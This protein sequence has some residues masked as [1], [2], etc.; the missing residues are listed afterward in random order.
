MTIALENAGA[1]RGVFLQERDGTWFV[2]AEATAAI[3]ETLE[4]LDHW[5]RGLALPAQVAAVQC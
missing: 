1:E 3:G 2:E 4:S 5:A